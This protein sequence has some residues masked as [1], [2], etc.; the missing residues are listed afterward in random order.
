MLSLFSGRVNSKRVLGKRGM[1]VC[2]LH[3]QPNG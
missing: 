2:G 3:S 1:Q